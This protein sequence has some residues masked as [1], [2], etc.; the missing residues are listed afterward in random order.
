MDVRS[1]VVFLNS[2]RVT[3]SPQ[4]YMLVR[5]GRP[6]YTVHTKIVLL[7]ALLQWRH[8][9]TTVQWNNFSMDSVP[10]PYSLWGAGQ[11]DCTINSSTIDPGFLRSTLY[12]TLYVDILL[13]RGFDIMCEHIVESSN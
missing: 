12:T 9:C 1:Y 13:T 8:W 4:I 11:P 7:Q 10:H 3:F 5:L 6:R 2:E